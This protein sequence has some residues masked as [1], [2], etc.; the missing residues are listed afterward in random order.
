MD[1]A[2]HRRLIAGAL[3]HL[4]KRWLVVIVSTPVVI[5]SVE[6]TVV[7]GKERGPAGGTDRVGHIGAV[8]DHAV[9]A[10]AV[11]LGRE[12]ER[13]EPASI[14]ADRLEGVIVAK[15]PNDIGPVGVSSENRG[16]GRQDRQ[17][18]P[19]QSSKKST[20]HHLDT[21]RDKVLPVAV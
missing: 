17:N 2:D 11:D 7:T 9:S 8:E 12:V 20:C 13:A 6:M 5:L 15:D 19:S 3:Q 21:P 18:A 10:Q 14:G 16:S 1:L 4:L